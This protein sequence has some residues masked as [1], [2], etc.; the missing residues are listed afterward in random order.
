M[1]EPG[2][3][4]FQ[5]ENE[6][7]QITQELEAGK[8]YFIKV[9]VHNS[10]NAQIPITQPEMSIVDPLI[11]TIEFESFNYRRMRSFVYNNQM[12]YDKHKL[13]EDENTKLNV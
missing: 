4:S 10:Q 8:T 1:V 11:G 2:L 7:N 3:Y 13:V 12:Q 6:S 5:L 9:S